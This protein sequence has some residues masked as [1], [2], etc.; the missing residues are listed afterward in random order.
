MGGVIE[1][2]CWQASG[3]QELTPGSLGPGGIIGNAEILSPVL[4]ADLDG[5]L[6]VAYAQ[7]FG[8]AWYVHVKRYAS[9]EGEGEGEG[10][11]AAGPVALVVLGL[12]LVA[13]L[14]TQVGRARTRTAR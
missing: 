6:Y 2:K 5:N 11:P 7:Y 4:E 3:W 9:A 14:A 10:M 8:D 12:L 13:G 1:G